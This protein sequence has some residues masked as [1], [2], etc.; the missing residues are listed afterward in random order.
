MKTYEVAVATQVYQ[1]YLVK[2]DSAPEEKK[3]AISYPS[4]FGDD[5]EREVLSVQE[6]IEEKIA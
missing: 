1:I 3:E 6:I 4:N 5:C 2:A